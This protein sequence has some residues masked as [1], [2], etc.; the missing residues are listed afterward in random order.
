MFLVEERATG[1]FKDPNVFGPFLI[2]PALA[3]AE[4]LLRER[5]RIA[6][7]AALGVILIGLLL[8]FSRGAW[9]HFVVSSTLTVFLCFV[10]AANQR[11][12]LRISL[13]TGI[14]VAALAVAVVIML[15]IPS[16]NSMLAER[17]HLFN[18]YDVGSGGR[19]TLQQLAL[20]AV[21]D[22]PNGMGPLEFG[23]INGLQQ[24]NVYL[25]AFLV[26]GWAG[27]M[28]YLLLI[29]AT[30]VIGLRGS[31]LRTHFQ[32]YLITA[33]AA[34]FG[35]M[36]EGF[37]IDTDHWRH[38]FLLIGIIWGAAAATFKIRAVSRRAIPAH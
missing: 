26:Y 33:T 1:M 11:L 9:F 7:L 35:E 29:G 37:I 10:T 8:S 16:V 20:S 14:S 30:L 27:A 23:R 13:L 19:F 3:L 18:S 6:G 22:Y 32:P 21:L 17:A 31:F 2:W 12:R 28:A 36:M 34:F 38:F 25:Q 4:R 5:F 24:H 15:S